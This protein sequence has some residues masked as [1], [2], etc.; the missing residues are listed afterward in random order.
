MARHATGYLRQLWIL[1][2]AALFILTTAQMLETYYQNVAPTPEVSPWPSDVLF[3]LWVTPAVIMLLPRPA[4]DSDVVDWQQVLDFA[5]VGIVALTAYLYFFYVPSRWEAE[6]Q[7]MVLKILQLQIFR[8]ALLAAGFAARAATVSAPSLRGFFGRMASLFF[9]ASA[10]GIV[11]LLHPKTFPFRA[12]WGDIAWSAP[13]LFAAVFAATWRQEHQHIPQGHRSPLRAMIVSQVLPIVTPLLVLLMGRRIAAE[14][15]TLAW[16]AVTASFLLSAGRL[17]L[18]NEKQRR[19]ADALRQTERALRHS[20]RMFFTAFRSGPD[21]VGISAIPGGHFLEVNDSFTRL[22]GYSHE[23]TLGRTA[24]EL[25]LW[26]DPSERARVMAKLQEEREV[27]EEEFLCQTKS[28][29]TRTCQFSGMLVD[30]DGEPCALVIVR[31]ITARKQAE[32]ALRASEERFRTLVRE[33]DVGVTLHGPH[34]EIQF[35]NQAAQ[36]M[37]E[38]Q[39][40]EAQG[41]TTAEL[42]LISFREDGTEIPFPMRPA[43]RT[44][45]TGQSIKDEVIGWRRPGLDN[46]LWTQGNVVPLLNREGNITGVISTFTDITERRRAEDALHQLSTR[47]LQLQDEERRRLG[48]ELHDSLAQTV[49]AVNL[50]L[51]QALQSSDSFSERSRHALAEGRRLLQEMSQEI[52][53]L[54]YLLHPPLLDEL[55]LVSAIKEYADGFSQRSGIA[56]DL[57]LP[58]GFGRLPQDTETALFRIVQESLSNIQRHSGSEAARISLRGGA[59]NV[60]LE[61]SDQGKGMG[62]ST[63]DLGIG[64]R[65]RLGVGI[66]GMRERMTQLGG[67]LDINSGPSGTTVR[68]TIPLRA[69]VSDA[70]SYPRR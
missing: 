66:L 20:E 15:V 67:K 59:A 33:M 21:A 68:A 18:T 40:K 28:G 43:P 38:I 46:V 42:D 62:D 1:L 19:V 48:R 26:K 69:E 70:G 52:R 4:E 13:Y 63:G 24:L 14:Q 35:A 45:R 53:T 8:D 10:S 56:L 39:L 61:V 49:L 12:D 51:A 23:E 2:A 27:R 29:E 36:K 25:N 50:N 5:Q 41:K 65:A 32:D 11:P 37:F 3:F 64:R 60:E 7:Q 55:G 44:I 54:S 22:T 17:A 34:A 9:L 47:L 30:V 57:D 6:G 58:D 31:D 16:I